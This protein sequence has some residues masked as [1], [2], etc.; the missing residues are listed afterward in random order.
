MTQAAR[1]CLFAAMV[2]ILLPPSVCPAQTPEE[3]G[4]TIATEADRRYCGY[5]DCTASL[6]MILRNRQG[7]VSARELRVRTLEVQEGGTK[8]LCIFD[9]P[10]DV[11]GT[12]LLTHTHKVQQDDQW[13]YLPALKRIKRIAAQNRSGSFMG[14]EFSY[15]DIA[16][17]V[18][19]KY[20]Y[21]WLREEVCDD[22][23]CYVIERRPA[24]K[25]NSGYTRQVV[26]IDKQE[27]RTLKVDYYD[28]KDSRLKTLSFTGYRKYLDRFWRPQDMTMVN[29]QTGKSS[30][31]IWSDFA[32]RTGLADN[33]FNQQSLTTIR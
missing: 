25:E 8:S 6:R 18:L 31:L 21:Q 13:L 11:K 27:Y 5:G 23:D 7:Q 24:D 26:W 33:D 1:T 29:H 15:E 22:Q 2:T 17:Q 12:I 32:F 14:S 19:E 10:R 9:S 4:L 30:Q 28:R 20:T 16:T 3:K